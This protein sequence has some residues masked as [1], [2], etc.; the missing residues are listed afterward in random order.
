MELIIIARREK[1]E[2]YSRNIKLS[3]L[4]TYVVDLN[5]ENIDELEIKSRG[6]VPI[7]RYQH[8]VPHFALIS[9]QLTEKELFKMQNTFS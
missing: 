1:Q 5:W 2:I 7:P 4:V 8:S 3:A 9:L 6:I